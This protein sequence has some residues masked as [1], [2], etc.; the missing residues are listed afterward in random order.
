MFRLTQ[1]TF[2]LSLFTVVLWTALTAL[3]SAEEDK[4]AKSTSGGELTFTIRTVTAGGNYSPKHVLAIWIENNGDFVK[5]RKAMANQRKQ[6]LYTWKAASNY[7]VVDAITG[8]TL[9]SHQTHTVTWD[10]TDLDGNIVPDGEY[11]VY[12]EFTDK[13][14]QGPLYMLSFTKGPDGVS[15]TPADEPYFKDIELEFIP[16]VSEFMY[17]TD[18]ICQWETVTYTDESVNADSWEWD[19]GEGAAPATANT[20]GPHTV[21]YTTPGSK[22]VSLTINDNITETKEDL[23]AV[24]VAPDAD[25]SYTSDA[26]T[27][28]FTNL[29]SNATTYLWDFGDGNSS[30]DNNPTHT[31][32]EA[33]TFDVTLTA[34]YLDCQD[35]KTYQ[36]AVPLVGMVEQFNVED[37]GISPNPGSGIFTL[38][39]DRVN[40]IQ[41]IDIFALSGK[42]IQVIVP[43]VITAS[44]QTT[45]DVRELKKGI[46]FLRITASGKVFTKKIV[47]NR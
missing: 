45:I 31:Y 37:F 18:A 13:H 42:W 2:L 43:N 22:T 8:S 9:T 29:S 20:Q 5:T 32:A 21:Y 38:K 30:I 35:F 11:D 47:I 15:L 1:S 40:D 33:G 39:S 46:Y 44:S 7:N 36:V 24:T 19:F 16:M 27:V 4:S 25:F 17:D 12:A 26:L 6:Y 23:I 14:A 3:H 41:K 28:E 10:C 34:S